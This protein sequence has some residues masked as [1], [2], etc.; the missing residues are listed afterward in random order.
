MDF[1]HAAVLAQRRQPSQAHPL[2]F[3]YCTNSALVTSPCPISTALSHS[4]PYYQ[5]TTHTWECIY[6]ILFQLSLSVPRD[7]LEMQI[8]PMIFEYKCSLPMSEVAQRK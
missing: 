5:A 1:I 7:T 6:A 8:S 3:G 2:L 4:G